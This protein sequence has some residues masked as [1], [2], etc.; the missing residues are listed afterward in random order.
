LNKKMAEIMDPYLVLG[1][2][3]AD[4]PSDLQIRQAYR[5]KALIYHPDRN[6]AQDAHLKFKEAKQASVILLDQEL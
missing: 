2:N 5:R 1:L 4:R 3:Y 6:S